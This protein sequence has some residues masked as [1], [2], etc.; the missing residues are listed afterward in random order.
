[1]AESHPPGLE[2]SP[3]GELEGHHQFKQGTVYR[4]VRPTALDSNLEVCPHL[5]LYRL[6][7]P[8]MFVAT[9]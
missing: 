9:G 3:L 5:E 6:G 1:M 8:R 2:L 7:V 4:Q